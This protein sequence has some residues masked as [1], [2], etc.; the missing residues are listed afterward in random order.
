M[1]KF[2][3]LAIALVLLLAGV[4]E[5]VYAGFAAP[6]PVAPH[7]SETVVLIKSGA[8]LAGVAQELAG[9]GVVLKPGLFK[10]GVRLHGET[11]ELKAGEYAI[12]SHASMYDIMNILMAGHSIEHKLTIAEGLTSQMAYDLVKAD[13]V[14][15]G[16]A[17]PVP[18]EGALLPETYLFVRGTTRSEIIAKM[19]KAQQNLIDDLWP[20]RAPDLPFKTKE[21]AVILASI[22]EKESAIPAE[23]RHVASVFINRL[24]LGMKLQSDPTIIYGITKGYPLGRGIR[25]SEIDTPTPF[26]TYAITGLPPQPI[27]NPGKDSLEAVLNPADTKDLYFVA[28]GTGGHV[29]AATAAEQAKNVAKWRK[30]EKEQKK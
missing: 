8:G 22:V 20:K 7:G 23:R 15:R 1:K 3:A 28:D 24:R 13:P 16:D 4:V 14:L 30:I 17:G 10:L 12:P 5:W 21:Q 26:N 9:A 27:C 11:A 19:E 29:F 2:I 18:P 25:Q 6:G